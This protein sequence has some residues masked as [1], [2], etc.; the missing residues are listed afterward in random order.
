[1]IANAIYLQIENDNKASLRKLNC[2]LDAAFILRVLGY[3]S[4]EENESAK[5]LYDLLVK[6]GATIN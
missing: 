2:Y 6:Y 3:K 1:M 4:D 5:E